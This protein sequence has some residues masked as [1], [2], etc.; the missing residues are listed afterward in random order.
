M[1]GLRGNRVGFQ[2][3]DWSKQKF[4]HLNSEGTILVEVGLLLPRVRAESAKL[5]DHEPKTDLWWTE[6]HFD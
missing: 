1:V 2:T 4:P 5:P 6:H 3:N